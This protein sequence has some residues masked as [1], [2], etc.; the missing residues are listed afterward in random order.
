[1]KNQLEKYAKYNLWANTKLIEFVKKADPALFDKEL[2][3]SF[4]TIRLT[5]YHMWDAEV[6]W[7]NR[8]HS[9]SL[10]NWPSK[11]FHGSIDEFYKLFLEQSAKFAEYAESNSEDILKENFTYQ[12]LEGKKFTNSRADIIQHVMN[13]STFHRGQ[14]VTMLRNGGFTELSSTDYISFIRIKN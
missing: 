3:S 2:I 1:M 13:H 12:S 9:K 11:S 10:S 8:L 5:L 14:I 6:L 7:Y 4:K